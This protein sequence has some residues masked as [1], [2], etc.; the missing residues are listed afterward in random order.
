MVYINQR[1]C[2]PRHVT[3]KETICS[4]DV[5]LLAVSLRPFYTPRE[6][7]H[8]IIVCV[9]VPPSAAADT[10]CDVIHTTVARLQTQN[11]DA[12]LAISGDFNHVTLNSTLTNFHQHVVCNT[13]K[14]RTIDLLYTN[15]RDAYNCT[16]LPPLGS[17]D[18]NLIHL[19][20]VYIPK[21]CLPTTTRTVRKWTRG[22]EDAL[23]DCFESTDWSVLQGSGNLDEDTECTADYLNFCM[24]VAV[25]TKSVRCYPNNKPWINS[26][27][28]QLL[29]EKKKAFKN[30]DM[31]KLKEVQRE[32]KK[33]L[34]E[35]KEAYGR[36]MEGKMDGNAKEL[37]RG[38]RAMTGCG[39]RSVG[40]D[41]D[42]ERA[43]QLNHFYV[44][45]AVL[46]EELPVPTL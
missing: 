41:G 18:H 46:V 31:V 33:G 28:R 42:V 32:L 27:V 45:S 38:L 34:R 7:S 1:F 3:I 26:S 24:E 9:Y 17:S 13:R 20:P 25:P 21:V 10:A 19:Q 4:R 12:F 5:E 11:T 44:G 40:A 36:K 37:W 35:A 39:A 23:R 2:N 29:K 16:P 22:A 6:F 30:G 43:N 14:T 15:V 8:V